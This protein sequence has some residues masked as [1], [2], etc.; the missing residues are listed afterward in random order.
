MWRLPQRP[1]VQWLGDCEGC[2]ALFCMVL[3]CTARTTPGER[4]RIPWFWISTIAVGMGCGLGALRY[5]RLLG[6]LTGGFAL[7]ML[8]LLLIALLVSHLVRNWLEG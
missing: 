8:G 5:G 7:A 3:A 4:F 6:Q 2:V 1:W